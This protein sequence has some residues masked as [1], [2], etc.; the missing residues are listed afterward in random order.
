MRHLLFILSAKPEF[1]DCLGFAG[2]FLS[3]I[4]TIVTLLV[5]PKSFG[6]VHIFDIHTK[7]FLIGSSVLFMQIYLMGCYLYTISA[8][9]P[10]IWL[11]Q[12][13]MDMDEANIFFVLLVLF[14]IECA[15]TLMIFTIWYQSNFHNLMQS[16]LLFGLVQMLVLGGSFMTGLLT[17]AILKNFI[18]RIR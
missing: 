3:V 15:G 18:R 17:N 13:F 2:L 16:D 4:L 8:I 9:R 10:Y 5:G 11:T 7:L 6:E 1:F 14:V 12:K